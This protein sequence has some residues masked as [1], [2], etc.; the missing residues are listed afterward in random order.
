MRSRADSQP[1]P[2]H[3]SARLQWPL[4]PPVVARAPGAGHPPLPVGSRC[5]PHVPRSPA[6]RHSHGDREGWRTTVPEATAASNTPRPGNQ[7]AS[8]EKGRR[9]YG[10]VVATSSSSNNSSGGG[11]WRRGGCPMMAELGIMRGVGGALKRWFSHLLGES[12]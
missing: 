9:R 8:R 12:V 3:G 4:R 10:E 1:L 5:P 2:V 7:A 6:P 11:G